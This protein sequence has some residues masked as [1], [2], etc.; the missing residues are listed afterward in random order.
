MKKFA[1]LFLALIALAPPVPAQEEPATP[2]PEPA[3]AQIDIMA[4]SPDSLRGVDVT[5]ILSE[6]HAAYG[7]KKYE[8]AARAFI[9][10]LRQNPGDSSALYNLAC[11]YGLLEAE[12][13]AASFLEAAY[14]AGFRDIGHIRRD[15]DFDK[16]RKTSAF[17]SAFDRLEERAGEEKAAKGDLLSVPARHLLPV[18]V[19][20]P[21]G[22]DRGRRSPLVIALHGLGD[23]A[24][25]FATMFQRRGI[26]VPFLFAVP[27]APYPYGVRA[28]KIG[29][30]WTNH[31]PEAGL[32]EGMNSHRLT[33]KY[34][35]D[36]L[37]AVK[38]HYLVDERKVFLMG[39]SQ[40]AGMT[41]SVG[42]DHPDLFRGLIPIGG[43]CDPGEHTK[44]V[45]RKA[46]RDANFLVCHSPDDRVV[47]FREA[48]RALTFLT[49][50]EI[51]HRLI[52]YEG[53]HTL[54]KDL[55]EE[56]VAWV[57]ECCE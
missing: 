54:P 23:N 26:D 38:R 32:I 51:T 4:V 19:V 17:V 35:L 31:D 39:F 20:L 22:Y 29:Y 1:I 47:P 28:S 13:Q 15:P 44:A 45:V 34:V 46:A 5:R 25:S 27:E 42:M 9:R 33:E 21:K 49:A 55:M 37:A 40:G 10:A 48:E 6:A 14:D 24:E 11:C 16:V 57:K 52:R 3:E 12:G 43:W 53:G 18:R 7:A 41:F 36:V 56:V 30:S 8:D 50:S 2:V